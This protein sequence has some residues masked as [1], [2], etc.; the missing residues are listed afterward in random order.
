[1]WQCECNT[2][3]DLVTGPHILYLVVTLQ[4][5]H[6]AAPLHPWADLITWHDY[7]PQCTIPNIFS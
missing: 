7:L 2:H 5:G 1:M 4:Q 6:R 3:P